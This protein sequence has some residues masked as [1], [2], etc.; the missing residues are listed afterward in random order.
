MRRCKLPLEQKRA[1]R[2]RQATQALAGA[3]GQVLEACRKTFA[4]RDRLKIEVDRRIVKDE[5]LR[6]IPP[7]GSDYGPKKNDVDRYCTTSQ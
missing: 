3:N 6:A 5:L 2:M 1:N 7:A 4:D